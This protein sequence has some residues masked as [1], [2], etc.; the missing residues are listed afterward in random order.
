[1]T[2]TEEVIFQIVNTMYGQLFTLDGKRKYLTDDEIGR[3]I[4]IAQ[5]QERGEVRC[6]CH[7]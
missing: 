3:F 7:P 4:D 1:M 5:Q 6:A 2:L